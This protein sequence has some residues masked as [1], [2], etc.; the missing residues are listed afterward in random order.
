MYMAVCA[1]VKWLERAACESGLHQP[2][3]REHGPPPPL[4]CMGGGGG[5]CVSAVDAMACVVLAMAIIQ[6]YDAAAGSRG[7]PIARVRPPRPHEEGMS[8]SD[9]A[10]GPTAMGCHVLSVP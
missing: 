10:E 9:R 1:R 2:P 3:R 7:G 8:R 5:R 4:A 6:L